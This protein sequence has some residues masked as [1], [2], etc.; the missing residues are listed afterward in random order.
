VIARAAFWAAALSG[1]P[2]TLYALR[3][4]R[5]P[6]EASRAAGRLLLPDERG[7]V[8]LVGAAAVVH[9]ALSLAWT[10]VIARTL[11]REAGLTRSVRHGIVMG[12]A[13]AVVDLGLAHVLRSP[14]FAAIRALPLAPQVADHLAFGAVAGALLRRP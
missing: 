14:R 2:S 8:P 5:D 13:I 12:G 1:A 11:P 9:G 3:T 4:G 10:G 6:L 7:P